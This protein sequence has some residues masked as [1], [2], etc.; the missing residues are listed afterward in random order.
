MSNYPAVKVKPLLS[1]T[2]AEIKELQSDFTD[3]FFTLTD[4]GDS[5]AF[6]EQRAQ[7]VRL[8]WMVFNPRSPW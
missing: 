2:E 7:G 1:I 5:Y 8:R 4:T 3:F 6:L